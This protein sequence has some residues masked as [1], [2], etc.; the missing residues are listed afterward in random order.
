MVYFKIKKCDRCSQWFLGDCFAKQCSIQRIQPRTR[1][2]QVGDGVGGKGDAQPHH[3]G[4]HD[5]GEVGALPQHALR[6][7]DT[8]LAA[9]C[10]T[11]GRKR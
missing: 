3:V 9:A 8:A 2:P 11:G 6:D 4:A 5:R 10:E 7:R 1:L